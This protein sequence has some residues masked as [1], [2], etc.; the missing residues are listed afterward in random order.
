LLL[1]CTADHPSMGIDWKVRLRENG[2]IIKAK[3]SALVSRDGALRNR[4]LGGVE[5]CF[6]NLLK[7]TLECVW[8]NWHWTE[9]LSVTNVGE[10]HGCSRRGSYI[11]R[12]L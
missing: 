1:R 2:S 7:V 5:T 3:R 8:V 12:Y 11:F 10:S 9:L 6:T 4:R